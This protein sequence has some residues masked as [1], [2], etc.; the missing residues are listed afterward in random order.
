MKIWTLP[1]ILAFIYPFQASAARI[2]FFGGTTNYAVEGYLRYDENEVGILNDSDS[3]FS[4]YLY[5][6]AD[7]SVSMNGGALQ[8]GTVRLAAGNNPFLTEPF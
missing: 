3:P 2:D 5:K 4:Y 8:S 7:M 6:A 1:A